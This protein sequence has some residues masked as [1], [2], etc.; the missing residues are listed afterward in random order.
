M[1]L[2]IWRQF[3]MLIYCI[4]TGISYGRCLRWWHS[5]KKHI[6]KLKDSHCET[7][8]K[9]NT[10]NMKTLISILQFR[11]R[12]GWRHIRTMYFM[13]AGFR[14]MLFYYPCGPP[15]CTHW[16]LS[17]CDNWKRKSFLDE[18][19]PS[20]NCHSNIRQCNS[21]FLLFSLSV[22]RQRYNKRETWASLL[23]QE[24]WIIELS[25]DQA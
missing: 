13:N 22:I 3:L 20:D 5:R 25:E 18:S 21:G 9:E 16:P 11:D 7:W 4:Y 12:Y 14:P 10:Y 19:N 23:Y 15:K 6:L 17:L 2:L 24:I 8:L 1:L